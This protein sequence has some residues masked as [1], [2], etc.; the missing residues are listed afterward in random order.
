M[1]KVLIVEDNELNMDMLRRRLTRAGFQV[2][3]A[4]DGAIAVSLAHAERPDIILMDLSLPVLDGWAAT[5]LLKADPT[6]RAV[7]V[8]ALTAHAMREDLLKAQEAGCDDFDTKPVELSRLLT[9]MAAL[10][11]HKPPG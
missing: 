6:L 10:L 9:K 1:A 4:A 5:R 2:V 3:S 11:A 8:I 7:P